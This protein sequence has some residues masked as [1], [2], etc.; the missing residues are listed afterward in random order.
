MTLPSEIELKLTA[1]PALLEQVLAWDVLAPLIK[2]A[3]VTSQLTSLYYDTPHLSLRGRKMA[4]RLRHANGEWVQSVKTQGHQVEGVWTRGELETPSD[5]RQL[6]FSVITDPTLKVFLQS[7]E[8]LLKPRF[9]TDFSRVAQLLTCPDGTVLELAL[10]QGEVRA[11]GKTAALCE[12]ELELV[13]GSLDSLVALARQLREQF[14]LQPEI[15]SKAE[16]GYAL[17]QTEEAN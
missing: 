5:G 15:I 2:T 16:K 3:P 6:D 10:D 14:N 1:S 17:L 12:I 8:P 13:S 4:L 9:I 11:G 7:V